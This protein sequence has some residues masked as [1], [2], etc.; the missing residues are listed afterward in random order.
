VPGIIFLE[1]EEEAFEGVS[2]RWKESTSAR[3]RNCSGVRGDPLEGVD[4]REC[5]LRPLGV[6]KA[7][8][9]MKPPVGSGVRGGG[10]KP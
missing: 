7:M 1:R 4:L 10:E 2:G 3:L 6:D 8:E 9:G 5:G